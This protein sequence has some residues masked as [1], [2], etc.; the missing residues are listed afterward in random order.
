MGLMASNTQFTDVITCEQSTNGPETDL[1]SVKYTRIQKDSPEYTTVYEGI[2]QN[3]DVRISTI[4][5]HAAP[6]PIISLYDFIMATFVSTNEQTASTSLNPD[7][8][9]GASQSIY[10][11][12]IKVVIKLDSVQGLPRF[13]HVQRTSNR[14]S[15][16]SRAD[17]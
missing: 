15:N 11:S 12:K 8:P 5:F 4:V 10:G 3:V 17:Q 7:A 9:Q 2:D 14:T 13:S 16:I 1:L 6:E